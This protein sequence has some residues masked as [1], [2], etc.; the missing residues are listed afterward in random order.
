M[1]NDISRLTEEYR[2]II[3]TISQ[4]EHSVERRIQFY[5]EMASK[6]A[7][8]GR[9]IPIGSKESNKGTPNQ[10]LAIREHQSLPPISNR[11]HRG[12]NRNKYDG[13]KF[14][15]LRPRKVRYFIFKGPARGAMLR[16]QRRDDLAATVDSWLGGDFTSTGNND[17]RRRQGSD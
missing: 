10:N 5:Q 9:R 16:K 2:G 12:R 8:K 11:I 1:V 15:L 17:S 7:R 13:R 14:H 4:R 6:R 3:H